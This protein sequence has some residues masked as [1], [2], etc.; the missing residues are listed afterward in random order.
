MKATASVDV[1][2]IAQEKF[3]TFAG[4][5]FVSPN[6]KRFFLFKSSN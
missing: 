6:I 4:D 2:A 5:S 3:T 1:E